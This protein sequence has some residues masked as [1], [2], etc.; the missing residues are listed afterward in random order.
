MK[1]RLFLP[2]KIP[3]TYKSNDTCTRELYGGSWLVEDALEW[4]ALS[5]LIEIELR[6]DSGSKEISAR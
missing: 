3:G 4:S 5:S 2:E 6:R 1:S